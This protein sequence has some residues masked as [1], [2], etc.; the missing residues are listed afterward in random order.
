M[1]NSLI[2]NIFYLYKGFKRFG[3]VKIYF[4]F[5]IVF[6]QFTYEHNEQFSINNIIIY[7]IIYLHM[8]IV[9]W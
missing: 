4:S 7:Y 9:I 6:Y 5:K 1:I 3:G 2:L 8:H